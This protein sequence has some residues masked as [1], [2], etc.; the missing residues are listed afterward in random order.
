ML[1]EI[2]N[3]FVTSVTQPDSGSIV[4]ESNVLDE[5]PRTEFGR[6]A[7]NPRKFADKLHRCRGTRGN[8]S[9]Q[10]PS[11]GPMPDLP[12]RS[13][14]IN[15]GQ[16]VPKSGKW[17]PLGT[18]KRLTRCLDIPIEPRSPKAQLECNQPPG[19]WA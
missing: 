6:K 4:L 12:R 14:Q 3:G 10:L 2:G 9:A 7:F 8:E 16:L 18:T 15:C 13:R 11:Q 19:S 1:F 17:G 5:K